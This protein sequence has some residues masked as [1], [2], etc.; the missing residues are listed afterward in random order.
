MRLSFFNVSNRATFSHIFG[1]EL[2]QSTR[3]RLLKDRVVEMVLSLALEPEGRREYRL[4][5]D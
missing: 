5:P 1:D 4:L 2:F 3:Q